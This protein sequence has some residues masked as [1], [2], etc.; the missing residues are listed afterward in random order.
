M[1]QTCAA[2]VVVDAE[3]VTEVSLPKTKN[4]PKTKAR[5]RL[6]L[7]IMNK[8]TTETRI[9]EDEKKTALA[10]KKSIWMTDVHRRKLAQT[11][12]PKLIPLST[13]WEAEDITDDEADDEELQRRQ[14]VIDNHRERVEQIDYDD[15]LY[16]LQNAGLFLNW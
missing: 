4:N 12:R 6:K 13:I 5:L 2:A 3:T 8:E 10:V 14:R 1:E 15:F 16:G 11:A 9:K 7:K